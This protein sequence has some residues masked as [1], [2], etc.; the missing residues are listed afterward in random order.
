MITRRRPAPIIVFLVSGESLGLYMNTRR[1]NS[2]AA[3]PKSTSVHHFP[4][5]QGT[6]RASATRYRTCSCV[7]FSPQNRKYAAMQR[8][9]QSPPPPTSYTTNSSSNMLLIVSARVTRCTKNPQN[10]RWR[11]VAGRSFSVIMCPNSC[12]SCVDQ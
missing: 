12:L 6:P 7:R 11:F 2:F 3:T 5:L 10:L 9:P 1:S 4:Y 8:G